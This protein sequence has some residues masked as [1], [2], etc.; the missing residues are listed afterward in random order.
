ML[1]LLKKSS[2]NE[3]LLRVKKRCG[4]W[5][6]KSSLEI[7]SI[8]PIERGV[9]HNGNYFATLQFFGSALQNDQNTPLVSA[10]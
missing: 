2:V 4:G 6:E 1:I 8:S 5:K 10:T 9:L 7:F 3:N